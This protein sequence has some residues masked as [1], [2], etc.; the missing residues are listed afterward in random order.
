MNVEYNFNGLSFFHP[1]N[2][3]NSSIFYWKSANLI[4][5]ATAFYLPTEKIIACTW[6]FCMVGSPVVPRGQF[7][8]RK[9]GLDV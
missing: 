2:H 8:H 4:G 9:I 6:P 3:I 1:K 7:A 5:S